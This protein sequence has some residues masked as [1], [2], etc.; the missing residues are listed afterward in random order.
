M[1]YKYPFEKLD[2]WQNSRKLVKDTYLITK[3][4]PKNE[5]FGI[6]SQIRRSVVSVSSN[7]AEGSGRKNGKDQA[8]FSTM[9]FS[10]LME[11]TNQLILSVDL[12]FM[13]EETLKSLRK[14]IDKIANQLNALRKYQYKIKKIN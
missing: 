1:N 3:G 13:S 14:D 2:V 9:A 12:N 5:Q 6:T 11:L 7:L 4:F 8:H 10:S